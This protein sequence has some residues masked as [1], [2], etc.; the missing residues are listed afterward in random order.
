[1]PLDRVHITEGVGQ[2][3]AQGWKGVLPAASLP[4]APCLEQGIWSSR[5]PRMVLGC[6]PL[7]PLNR[8]PPTR[9]TASLPSGSNY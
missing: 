2:G 6:A 4:L 5:D 9:T 3:G 8:R 7:T 1:V